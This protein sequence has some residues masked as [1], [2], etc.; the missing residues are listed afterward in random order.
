MRNIPTLVIRGRDMTITGLGLLAGSLNN[1]PMSRFS[2]K[3]ESIISGWN[4]GEKSS[5]EQACNEFNAWGE[6]VRIPL[7]VR[8]NGKTKEP[9]PDAG[10]GVMFG[11][12]TTV[13]LLWRFFWG[14]RDR[15]RLKRCPE[16]Q[17]WFVDTTRN[18]SMKRCSTACTNKW[19]TLERRQ[20]ARHSL[21]GAKRQAKR[22]GKP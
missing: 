22:R 18:G 20:Q 16:C 6:T 10:G 8:W 4:T 5:M 7:S 21:P 3:M 14:E 12:E 15:D 19:W 9:V 2:Q 11:E 17:I 13:Y 1:F